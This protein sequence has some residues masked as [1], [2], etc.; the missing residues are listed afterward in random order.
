MGVKTAN[1]SWSFL[2]MRLQH[3]SGIRSL[4]LEKLSDQTEAANRSFKTQIQGFQ[5]FP[6]SIQ[7]CSTVVGSR[8]ELSTGSTWL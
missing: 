2:V 1:I 6:K 7:R 8:G 5:D 3:N 4:C